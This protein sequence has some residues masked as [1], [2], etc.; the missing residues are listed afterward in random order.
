MS[1]EQ[2]HCIGLITA[3]IQH[4]LDV[5]EGL[6]IGKLK[7]D[8]IETNFPEVGKVIFDSLV[9]RV[10]VGCAALFSDPDISC[11]RENMSLK[12][13]HIKHGGNEKECT[14]S[15]F[16]KIKTIV[17]EMNIKQYRNRYIAHFD[18]T[19]LTGGNGNMTKRNITI[20]KLKELCSLSQEY[21]QLLGW[22]SGI[23]KNTEHMSYYAQIP[24]HRGTD[25]F[26][27]IL[28]S[29]PLN[30]EEWEVH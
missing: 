25:I 17:D 5:L 30:D 21:I 8:S 11:G 20:K 13:L 12:N 6:F 10:I 29:N 9:I 19:E 15:L 2:F 28:T 4:T 16:E 3:D 7:E 18:L 26:S 1:K 24:P 27:K 23:F 22:E 14:N